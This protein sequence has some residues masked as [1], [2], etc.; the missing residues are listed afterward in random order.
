MQYVTCQFIR[1]LQTAF[2]DL[3]YLKTTE[4]STQMWS[5]YF[6]IWFLQFYITFSF[7]VQYGNYKYIKKRPAFYII[8]QIF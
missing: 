2:T 6:Q 4:K 7:H 1:N 5:T 8:Y 3:I